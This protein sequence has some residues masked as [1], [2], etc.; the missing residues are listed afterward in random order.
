MHGTTLAV[1]KGNNRVQWCDLKS[2]REWQNKNYFWFNH[3]PSNEYQCSHQ[4]NR[5]PPT[6][7]HPVRNHVSCLQS[8]C[9]SGFEKSSG[10]S[11]VKSSHSRRSMEA[12]LAATPGIQLM[13]PLD[14]SPSLS[15]VRHHTSQVRLPQ[16]HSVRS[17]VALD[18]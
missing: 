9:D 2:E 7:V 14:F 16:G 17:G 15:V 1:G 13:T 4:F 6:V 12:I 10:S 3:P 18:I 11:Q 5:L 8:W